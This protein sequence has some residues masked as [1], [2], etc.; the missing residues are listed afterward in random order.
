MSRWN[1][2]Y[3]N[4]PADTRA[5][6]NELVNTIFR[7]QTGFTGKIDPQTQPALAAQWL[8]IRDSVMAN[9]HKFATW[10]Q[11]VGSAIADMALAIPIF[12]TLDT[13]PAWIRAA[14]QENDSGVREEKGNAKH[15]RIT[16]YIRTCTVNLKTEKQK[17]SW[18][19]MGE[20]GVEWCAC[21]VNWCLQ[22]A[23]IAGLNSAWAPSW[24]NWGT[25]LKGP[26]VGAVACFKWSGDRIQHVAFCDQ[27][28]GQWRMLG[29]NQSGHAYGGQ[30]SSAPLNQKAVTHYRW[31]PNL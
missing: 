22:Q 4:L 19:N 11:R 31:P 3:R 25:P 9:R 21:F 18:I 8:D 13:V 28:D 15:P 14:R 6:V 17:T 23:G 24:A 30:V 29:G 10:M 26:K 7:Q 12:K 20:D 1:Q 5:A 2:E 27:V 16:E